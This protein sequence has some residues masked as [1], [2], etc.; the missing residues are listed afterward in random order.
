M[1]FTEYKIMVEKKE[2]PSDNDFLMRAPH[3]GLSDKKKIIEIR[4]TQRKNLAKRE[5]N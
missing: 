1:R 2:I 3:L 4:A 5:N